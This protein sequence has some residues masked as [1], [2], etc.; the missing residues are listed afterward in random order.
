MAVPT[1]T[2]AAPTPAHLMASDTSAS[3]GEL[4]GIKD[5][6]VS[7]AVAVPVMS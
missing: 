5:R 2:S 3:S 7:R 4:M 1:K 6:R